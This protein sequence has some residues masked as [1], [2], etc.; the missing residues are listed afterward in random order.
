[1]V[2]II[3]P[4]QCF[5]YA[6][7]CC[8]LRQDNQL[9]SAVD[10]V[11]DTV[12]GIGNSALQSLE[13]IGLEVLSILNT[14]RDADKVIEDTDGLTLSLGDTSVGH[15]AGDLAE[16]L[17]TTEGLGK[18]EDLGVLAE[19]LS[20]GVTALDT[21]AQHAT[22]HAVAVL[23][24]SN[25]TV[26]VGVKTGVVDRDDEG[27]SLEGVGDGGRVGGGLASTEVK[28]FS[29]TVGEPRV[30]GRGNGTDGVLEEGETGVELVAVEGGNTHDN[31]GVAVDVLSHTMNNDIGTM[32][33][34]VLDVGA[35]EGV[36]DN[37]QDA[38]LMG[39]SS[40]GADIH[41]AE[42]RVAGGLDP[43]EL[44]GIGD[45]LADVNLDLR[46]EGDLDTV[47]LGDL[48]EVSVGAAVDVGD[49][50]DVGTSGERLEDVGGGGRTRRVGESVLGV[51][52]SS[53]HLLEVSAVGVT[54]AGVL[55]LADRLANG[56]LSE[57]GGERDGLDHGASG[58]VVRGSRVD[59]ER[60]EPMDGRGSAGRG[61]DGLVVGG[62]HFDGTV[63]DDLAQLARF[64]SLVGL[65]DCEEGPFGRG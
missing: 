35:Q 27:R 38:T 36:V 49:G 40:N 4:A 17:D 28:G 50:D 52:E 48:G 8:I 63:C 30:E 31:V 25:G 22:T 45:V 21:E 16:R 34:R 29:S 18:S 11:G 57:G 2:V 46:G 5:S 19:L 6:H 39:G 60:T 13:D 15:G 24:E 44:G 55:E 56:R 51:L 33:E 54:A 26:G 43:H 42:G 14:A 7:F 20:S 59:G 53:N 3:N 41:K 62:S 64:R 47:G 1:M 32:V 37:D 10:T 12:S 65:S 61:G 58:G 23:L 9:V